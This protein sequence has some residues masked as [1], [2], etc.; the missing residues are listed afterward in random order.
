ME[1][2]SR[3]WVPT[4]QVGDQ[5]GVPSPLPIPGHCDPLRSDPEEYSVCLPLLFRLSMYIF[6]KQE[7]LELRDLINEVSKMVGIIRK[8]E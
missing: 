4:A 6:K 7:I 1:G 3:A 8:I 2:L 5:D